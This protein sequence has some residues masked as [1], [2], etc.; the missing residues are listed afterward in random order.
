MKALELWD[1]LFNTIMEQ[2]IEQ[3]Q[4][5]ANKY[6]DGHYTIMKFTTNYK[7]TFGT[8]NER[9]Q[10]DVLQGFKT[11]KEAIINCLINDTTV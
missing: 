5:R 7:A 10:I 2:L 8:V 9:E 1:F 3:L 4:S 11:L 6:H